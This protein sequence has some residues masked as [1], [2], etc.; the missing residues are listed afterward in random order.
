MHNPRLLLCNKM[1]DQPLRKPNS[2]PL[3][4]SDNHDKAEEIGGY[5]QDH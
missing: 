4:G 1:L 3:R 5:R 2:R